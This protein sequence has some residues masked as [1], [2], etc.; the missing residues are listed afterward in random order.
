[1]ILS[2]GVS[3][4]QETQRIVVSLKNKTDKLVYLSTQDAS[5]YVE[6]YEGDEIIIEPFSPMASK[7]I[8]PEEARG[9]I[10]VTALVHK[11]L[12]LPKTELT[13][14]KITENVKTLMISLHQTNH[15]NL[16]IKVPINIHMRLS[17]HTSL[18]GATVS[19]KNLTGEL[20][21]I[22]N[23]PLVEVGNVSGPVFIRSSASHNSN[24][25]NLAQ[26]KWDVDSDNT[27]P[28]FYISSGSADVNISLP[29]N[30]KATIRVN[31]TYGKLF[32]DLNLVSVESST[33]VKNQYTGSL[34]GGGALIFISTEYG[35]IYI[36]TSN[37]TSQIKP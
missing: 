1:M 30:I 37:N 5:I 35:N 32:S 31:S 18:P 16:L 27:K 23:T 14:P 11:R 12:Q 26:I 10:N 21:L 8:I 25:I 13:Q 33:K 29:A 4:S 36:K 15:T 9:L 24:Q 3:F 28:R 19:L 22:G 17:S 2:F 20:E 34:N 7:K 6:G